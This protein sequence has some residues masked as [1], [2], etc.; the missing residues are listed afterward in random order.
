ME[1]AAHQRMREL[2]N[3]HWWFEARRRILESLISGLKPPAGARILEVGCGPGGNLA[4]LARFGSVTGVEPDAGARR[5]AKGASAATVRTGLLPDGLDLPKDTY[6][7]VCAFDVLEHVT[8]DKQSVAALADL[9]K[10]GGWIAATVPAY[11]WMWSAHDEAHH[12]KRRYHRRD[13]E[14]LFTDAGL[15]LVKSSH[16]NAV[17]LPLAVAARATKWMLGSDS[18]DDAMPWPWVNRMLLRLMSSERNWLKC[19]SLPIGLSLV[20]IARR[21]A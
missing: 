7:L 21:L 14:A 4:M 16:F 9:V 11:P 10:P 3:R 18:P 19:G 12:H 1:Q 5:H 13:F 15:S 8:E 6:D 17:L 2:Q 20:V